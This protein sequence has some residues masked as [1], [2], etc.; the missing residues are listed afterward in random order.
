MVFSGVHP[1]PS[2]L[3]SSDVIVALIALLGAGLG[4]AL[5][6]IAA[7]R[8]TDLDTL[9]TL[10]EEHRKDLEAVKK[11]MAQ[12]R[13][14]N[15]RLARRVSYLMGGIDQLMAQM[16]KSKITPIWKPDNAFDNQLD[17]LLNGIFD[18]EGDQ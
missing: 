8:K 2:Y 6:F 10:V 18:D 15:L 11:E 16:R 4:A 13:M 5:T 1:F 14:V 7:K 9:R 3:L 12:M 17:E